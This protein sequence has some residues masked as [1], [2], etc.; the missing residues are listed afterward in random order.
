MVYCGTAVGTIKKWHHHLLPLRN[1]ADFLQYCRNVYSP[2]DFCINRRSSGKGEEKVYS[3][4]LL[5][6]EIT[7]ITFKA[8][9]NDLFFL[10]L[11][12]RVVKVSNQGS[13]IFILHAN[14]CNL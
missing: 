7:K 11:T 8:A 3:L 14:A 6:Q 1:L 2:S 5:S 9:T 4:Q 12:R 10:V 13:D